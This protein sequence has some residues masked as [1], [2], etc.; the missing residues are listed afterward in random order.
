[1]ALTDEYRK[2]FAWRDW[3]SALGLCPI[4]EGQRILDLG[5]GPGDLAL[6]LTKR[7][8]SVVGVDGNSE[9]IAAAQERCPQGKFEKQDLN[10]LSLSPES[11]DGLW[12]SFTAAYFTDFRKTFGEWRRFL[13]KNAW[14]C[15]IEIDDLLGHAPL[16]EASSKFVNEFY[17]KALISGWYDFN[18]GRKIGGFLQEAGFRVISTDLGDRELSF[19]GP[20]D[21][22]VSQAWADRLNRMGGLK[23]HLGDRFTA[24]REEFLQCL[25]SEKHRSRCRVICHVAVAT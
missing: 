17:N 2:Q 7:G 13:K 19:N 9:L 16:S 23:S 6:E 12:C 24:F 21:P 11:F 25:S 15:I 14:V 1:M 10:S 18:A 20:A 22:A 8:A 4:E 5:C 3:S